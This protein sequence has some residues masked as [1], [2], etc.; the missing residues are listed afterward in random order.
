ML[1]RNRRILH[2]WSEFFFIWSFQPVDTYFLY[3]PRFRIQHIFN[4]Y[5]VILLLHLRFWKL[6]IISSFIFSFPSILVITTT[7]IL[8]LYISFLNVNILFVKKAKKISP[9]HLYWIYY[10]VSKEKIIPVTFW[11]IYS[12]ISEFTLMLFLHN[13]TYSLMV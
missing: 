13:F 2:S 5:V 7:A 4:R 3:H 9:S 1:S 10:M 12:K 11:Y 8:C 6:P